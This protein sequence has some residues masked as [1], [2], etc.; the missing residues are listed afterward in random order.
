MK[1]HFSHFGVSIPKTLNDNLNNWIQKYL[2]FNGLEFRYKK[3]SAYDYGD[4][5]IYIGK[6]D[7]SI[8]TDFRQFI[9]EYNCHENASN[10]TLTFLHELGHV[11]TNCY[12]NDIEMIILCFEK[13][14]VDNAFDYWHIDDE[15][16]ANMFVINFMNNNP[17]AIRELDNIFEGWM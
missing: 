3:E 12:F 8:H 15:F 4:N 16:E 7:K 9:Y 6:K 14:S 17:E 5:I 10:Q 13:G 11:L 2:H 1:Y